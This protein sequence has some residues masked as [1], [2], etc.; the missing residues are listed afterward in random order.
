MIHLRLPSVFCHLNS[1]AIEL[2]L[3]FQ[4]HR[5]LILQAEG[6][7]LSCQMP[8]RDP[9]VKHQQFLHY[10][11]VL[12]VHSMNLRRVLSTIISTKT[13]GGMGEDSL[14]QKGSFDSLMFS[15]IVDVQLRHVIGL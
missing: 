15:Q 2:A 11:G 6:H 4:G 5:L 13:T 12:F 1:S 3:L 14:L 8:L 7:D 9:L 10:H